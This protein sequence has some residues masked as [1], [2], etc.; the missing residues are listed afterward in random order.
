MNEDY[1]NIYGNKPRFDT[2][3]NEL[4][5]FKKSTIKERIKHKEINLEK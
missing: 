2:R 3:K 4:I 1:Q 5:N